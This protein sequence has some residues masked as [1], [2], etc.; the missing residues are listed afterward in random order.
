MILKIILSVLLGGPCCPF[1][2]NPDRTGLAHARTTV[3]PYIR[4]ERA[5][6]TLRL[7]WETR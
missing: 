3:G 7:A 4:S 1:H 2:E 6:A 5:L